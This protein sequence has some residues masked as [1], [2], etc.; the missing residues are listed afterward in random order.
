MCIP[1]VPQP[2]RP[3]SRAG[4]R[5]NPLERRE[6]EP[7][8]QGGATRLERTRS[9][10]GVAGGTTPGGEEGGSEERRAPIGDSGG[11]G[12]GPHRYTHSPGLGRSMLPRRGGGAMSPD[13][14]HIPGMLRSMSRAAQPAP[15]QV[16]NGLTR[17]SACE[18][19]DMC[20]PRWHKRLVW[21]SGTN[22][23]WRERG[24]KTATRAGS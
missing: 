5:H 18:C 13:P 17:A 24:A 4:P 10:P 22:R 15:E 11:P 12:P 21:G 19:R 2:T 6:S 8:M 1:I 20:R 16:A 3:R 14:R 23:L 7:G 9:L